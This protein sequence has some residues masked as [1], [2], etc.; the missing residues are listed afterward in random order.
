MDPIKTLTSSQILPD[1]MNGNPAQHTK[2]YPHP[3]NKLTLQVLSC[4]PT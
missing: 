2:T 1:F 3:T 4:P